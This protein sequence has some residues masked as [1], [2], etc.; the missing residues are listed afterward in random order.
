MTSKEP[1]RLAL[2]RLRKLEVV[3]HAEDR[4]VVEDLLKAAGLGG[5]TLL[6]DVAGLG[7][8][9]T[10]Q[11]RA[12]FSDDTGLV[13]FVVVAEHPVIDDAARGLARLFERRPGVLFL[14]DV[15]VV[16]S[17]YFARSTAPAR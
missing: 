1:T 4:G 10:H 16:R 7:H 11:G 8:S 14:S 12:I 6:R 15:E 17:D 3:V 13:M 9:G 5:W 2:H